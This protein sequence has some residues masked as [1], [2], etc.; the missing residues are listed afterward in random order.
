MAHAVRSSVTLHKGDFCA[1]HINLP[2][3]KFLVVFNAFVNLIGFE[4]LGCATIHDIGNF[5]SIAAAGH[6]THNGKYFV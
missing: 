2:N 1:R 3:I 5:D 4:A 6:L